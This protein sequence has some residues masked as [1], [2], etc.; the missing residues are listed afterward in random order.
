MALALATFT[1]ED[2]CDRR[3]GNM[4]VPFPSGLNESCAWNSGLVLICDHT[5]GELSL[6]R[7]VPVYNISMENGT[8]T[9]GVFKSFDCYNETAVLGQRILFA[10][11]LRTEAGA[12]RA[13]NDFRALIFNAP[14]TFGS[15]CF[16]YCIRD[17]RLHG[18][19]CLPWPGCRQTSIPRSLNISMAS[20]RNYTW[21]TNSALADQRLS[22]TRSSL[23]SPITSF[24]SRMLCSLKKQSKVVVDWVVERDLTC[25]EAQSNQPSYSRGANSDCSDFEKG[26]G[27]RCFCKPGYTGTPYVPPQSPQSAGCRVRYTCHSNCKNTPGNYT[28]DCPFGVDGD[29]KVGCQTSRLAIIAAAVTSCIIVSGL[30]LFIC[31]RKARERHFSQ[32]GGEILKHQRVKIFTETQ[33]AKATN[34]YNA[35]N[36]LG[37]GGFTSVYK[38]RIDNNVLV[39]IKKPR[40]VF[41][42]KPKDM[43]KDGSLSTHDEFLHEINI[44]SQV[45]HKN[46]VKLLGICLE[47]KVPLMRSMVLQLW[48]NHLRIPSEAALALEYLHS[49]A[50][51]PVIH[52][53]VNLSFN[54]TWKDLYSRKIGHLN[55]EY[56]TIGELTMKSDVYSF[57]VVLTELFI[58]ETLTP[59]AKSREKIN[60]RSFISVVE[61]QTLLHMINFEASNEGEVREIEAV[62]LL[63][64]MWLNYNG[65]N[66][67][68]MWEA[69]EQLARINKNFWANQQNNEETQSLLDETRCDS[70]DFNLGNEQTRVN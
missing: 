35:S 40:D 56:L 33:L 43:N 31:K 6:G 61:N 28:C 32:N 55:S 37:E 17:V 49:L 38:G 54:I 22:W 39:V 9:I 64:R 5:L 52:C 68:T 66:R 29:G 48:K 63:A 13:W 11:P 4:S 19:G 60:I 47:T 20:M 8:I 30:I 2:S 18:R 62:G 50:N 59:W 46:L 51:P 12:E 45:N 42:K 21:F 67:P 53:D 57:R 27:Y 26:K 69:A 58:G 1:E 24:L 14:N 41:V 15:G 34:N 10:N 65:M 44:I 16:S 70:L 23:M 3:C 36:K 25:K 7:N